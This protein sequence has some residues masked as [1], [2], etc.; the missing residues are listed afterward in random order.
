MDK[1]IS[2]KDKMP[3]FDV[4]VIG[5][6]NLIE[7]ETRGINVAIVKYEE[8]YFDDE[9]NRWSSWDSFLNSRGDLLTHWMLIPKSP[10]VKE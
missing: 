6:F 9:S 4:Y 2:I 5:F 8:A 1:W 7:Q 10:E 3:D